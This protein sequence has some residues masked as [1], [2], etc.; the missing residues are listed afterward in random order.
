M[1][2]LC[3]SGAAA[4]RT[5]IPTDP[6]IDAAGSIR[7]KAESSVNAAR[8]PPAGC[9]L[10]GRSPGVNAIRGQHSDQISS[11]S[12]VD[13]RAHRA[14]EK[15]DKCR[16]HMCTDC[17]GNWGEP[18]RGHRQAKSARPVAL[19]DFA[20]HLTGAEGHP[21]QPQHGDQAPGPEG[22]LGASAR[23]PSRSPRRQ[24]R[25]MLFARVEGMALPLARWRPTFGRFR[26]LRK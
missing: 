17:P 19:K 18:Q 5:Q 25:P 24:H 7:P 16:A 14:P 22:A 3:A 12:D 21:Q 6:G 9:D 11:A 1:K 4:P 26:L 20:R 2:A 15:P 23:C 10:C 8:S 13:Y